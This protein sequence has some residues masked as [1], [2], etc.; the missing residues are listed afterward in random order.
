MGSQP[1][2][3]SYPPPSQ[4]WPEQPSE[5]AAPDYGPPSAYPPPP[6][7]PGYGAPQYPSYPAYPAPQGQP[8]LP[9][10]QP[11]YGA[12]NIYVQPAAPYP[13]VVA[14]PPEPGSGQ[15]VTS[16]VLGIIGTILAVLVSWTLCLTFIPII[17][18]IVGCIMGAL[19][20]KSKARHG[21][22]VAGFVLSIIAVA[23]PIVFAVVIVIADAA[24]YATPQ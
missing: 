7:A 18:G 22:A 4:P 8:P 10:A 12:P 17:L 1:P 3:G 15:A 6:M 16:L 2:Y 21:M 9:P 5:P 19:G 20:F 23:I 14:A 24:M 13:Y 11:M